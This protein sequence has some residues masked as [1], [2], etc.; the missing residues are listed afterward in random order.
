MKQTAFVIALFLFV[1]IMLKA[2]DHPLASRDNEQ[3]E[4]LQLWYGAYQRAKYKADMKQMHKAFGYLE[5]ASRKSG[6][7]DL[8]FKTWGDILQF[9]LVRG[10]TEYIMIKAKRMEEEALELNNMTGIYQ[11][12]LA[13]ARALCTADRREEALAK[14]QEIIE[15]P[16]FSALDKAVAHS[17]ITNVYKW[18]GEYDKAIAELKQ[19]SALINEWMEKE[20]NAKEYRYQMLDLELNFCEVYMAIPEAGSM[21]EHLKEVAKYYTPDCIFSYYIRYHT[22]W[23]GYYYLMSRWDDCFREFDLAL[24]HFN[25]VQPWY[26]ASVLLLKGQALQDAGRYREGADAYRRAACEMDSLNR[27]VL[28]RHEEAHQANYIIRQALLEQATAEKHYNRTWAL[29]IIVPALVLL[30]LLVRALRVQRVLRRSELETQQV[31]KTVEAANKMKESFLRN[32][33][34]Q[35]RVPLNIVVGFSEL[36]S[37]ERD[38]PKEQMEE[39]SAQVK[40][41]AGLLS[42]LIF[43]VLD[44]SRLES[45]MMKFN[46]QPCD[47]VELCREVKMMVE[48]EEGNAVRLTFHTEPDAL[49]I[50][51]DSERFMKLLL[52][53]LSA[54]EGCKEPSSVEYAMTCREDGMLEIVVHGSPLPEAEDKDERLSIQHDINRLYLETFKGTYRIEEENGKQTIVITYP[55]E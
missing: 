15:T 25:G 8:Y 33:I 30:T 6:Q 5:A 53:V 45:G 44:L 42:R 14:Y 35:I 41:N 3:T 16:D 21:L 18:T 4:E 2:G 12:K 48:M 1:S 50:Q 37:T 19:Q 27:D 24:A 43:D 7:Y 46:V 34:Y 26:E 28:H 40:T 13:M 22:C 52:S 38:L 51:A 54:P 17:E 47:A 9:S 29:L 20:G 11:S 55:I 31:L 32:I 23:A 36:L 39:Y 49:M 10:D